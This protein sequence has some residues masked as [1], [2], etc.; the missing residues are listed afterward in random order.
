MKQAERIHLTIMGC[1]SS[2]GV[3]RIGND[4]GACDPQNPKNRR[5]RPSVLVEG[6]TGDL[7]TTVIIDTGPDFRQQVLRHGVDWADG[8]LYTHPHADHCHGIDDLRAFVIN[9]RKRVQ[10]YGD[11]PML[12]RLQ[13]GFGYCFETPEGSAYPP[14]LDANEITI[15]EPVTIEG[16]GGSLTFLPFP[17][18]HGSI[19][20]LGF[21]I[22]DV[23]YSSDISAVHEDSHK[24]LTDLDLWIVDALQWKSHSSHFSVSQTLEA[25]EQH[26]PKHAVLTHMH[27]P[28]DYDV[29]AAETPDHVAPAFD[30]MSIWLDEL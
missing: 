24:A 18:H 22:G 5:T 25:I 17:Q 3:P 4:W 2:P 20:S 13:Q 29:V 26:K 21:R 12:K 1:G 8:V 6:F 7:K 23:A 30:G 27:T 14:I 9:R 16:E 11:A 15:G 10:V 28:L 19:I